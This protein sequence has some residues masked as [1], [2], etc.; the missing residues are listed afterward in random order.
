MCTYAWLCLGPI[1][2]SEHLQR[3]T[4]LREREAQRR[5]GLAQGGR[6]GGVVM[7]VSSPAQAASTYQEGR[8]AVGKKRGD[9]PPVPRHLLVGTP[10]R[11]S[12]RCKGNPVSHSLGGRACSTVLQQSCSGDRQTVDVGRVTSTGIFLWFF[13]LPLPIPLRPCFYGLFLG[14]ANVI[15]FSWF[16][17]ACRRSLP[18]PASRGNPPLL[19]NC[20]PPPLPCLGWAD[21]HYHTPSST[22]PAWS[23]PSPPVRRQEQGPG[24]PRSHTSSPP[25]AS[26]PYNSRS[27]D[28]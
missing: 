9:R 13:R 8:D 22:L 12:K 20:P 18:L 2:L 28:P 19:L 21:V 25:Q 16:S 14:E 6:H 10:G 24:E 4:G 15:H 7:L 11:Q 17:C 27:L 26:S 1:S 3:T 23:P 5:A